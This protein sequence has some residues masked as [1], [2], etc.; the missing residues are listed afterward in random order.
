MEKDSYPRFL[1]S[2]IYL[3]LLN[4]LQANSLKWSV[5]S[6]RELKMVSRTEE[7][8]Q[9]MAPWVNHLALLSDSTGPGEKQM[10]QHGL[11]WK[12]SRLR[13]EETWARWNPRDSKRKETLWYCCKKQWTY[14]KNLSELRRPGNSSCTETVNKGFETD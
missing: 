4:E 7:M 8:C 6:Q 3:N 10:I 13:V 2:N 5:P 14:Q 9:L 1:K 12:L 11:T